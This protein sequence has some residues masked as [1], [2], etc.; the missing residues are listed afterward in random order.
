V[1]DVQTLVSTIIIQKYIQSHVQPRVQFYV[2]SYVQKK[3]HMYKKRHQMYKK[4]YKNSCSDVQIFMIYVQSNVQSDGTQIRAFGGDTKAEGRKI[5][6]IPGILR[7]PD[8]IG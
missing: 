2:Q 3:H 8:R 7:L 6:G 4:I 1:Y 5:P